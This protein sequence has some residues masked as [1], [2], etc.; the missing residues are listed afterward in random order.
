MVVREMNFM[1]RNLGQIIIASA[2]IEDTVG[3]ILVA[4][5]FGLASSGTI[6]TASIAAI[7]GTTAF[8]I[9][10]LT[11]GRR[12]VS[13]LIRWTNDYFITEY[14]VITMILVIMIIMAL[15]TQLI[16]VNTVLGAFV[17]GIL[18]GESPILTRHIDEQ[19]RGLIVAL[20]MPIFFGL[21]GLGA[22]LTILE[23]SSLLLMTV[24]L[25]GI[26]SVG[27]FVGAFVGAG[28]GGLSRQEAL[29]LACAMNAR[30]STEVI[31]ASV[32]LSTGVL[33]SNLFTMI[34]TMAIITT[35]AMPPMLRWA[36]A[37]L[38]LSEEEQ[39]RLQ[40]EK[41]DAKGFVTRLERLLV[42]VDDSANGRLASR[43]A[44]LIAGSGGKPTTVMELGQTAPVS[45]NSAPSGIHEGF[46]K[47][48]ASSVVP[49]DSHP[50]EDKTANVDVITR[51]GVGAAREL[52]ADEARKGYDLLVVGIA[53]THL[54]EI[55]FTHEITELT[56][57]F[58]G[59]FAI[60]IAGGPAKSS[61]FA[62]A[63]IL[64]PINGSET[65]RRA[66]EVAFVL[67]RAGPVQITALY[68]ASRST[69]G[70]YWRQRPYSASMTRRNEEAALKAL[71]EMA[72]DLYRIELRTAIRVDVTA[73]EAIVKEMGKYDLVV[74]GVTRRPGD[75]L[76]FGKTA[77]AVLESSQQSIL[78]V[79]ADSQ[80]HQRN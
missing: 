41:L 4:L 29:A 11:L 28:L 40:R 51:S 52:V 77:A 69:V 7:L 62:F 59:P 72:E 78:F 19:L 65:A 56:N 22:D 5:A 55:G 6:G 1:R 67:A 58:D 45:D 12:V 42:A 35:M 44:G 75:T 2:I 23:N 71:A 50:N 3:W 30:G 18:V 21:S 60:A 80:P 39:K 46:V 26:A 54:P 43:M 74:M 9:L 15:T 33:S 38:P 16:G 10:S 68:V 66:A 14:P 49:L 13:D 76:F 17:A 64:V 36:L 48:A 31:V 37:R 8:L 61:D 20:F 79:A 53:A 32:G 57:G 63:R 27:K 73:E 47:R 25:I 24:A 34:V 70:S